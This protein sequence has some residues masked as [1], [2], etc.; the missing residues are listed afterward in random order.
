MSDIS[1]VAAILISLAGAVSSASPGGID[2]P[3]TQSALEVE[4]QRPPGLS[5]EV[6]DA[7]GFILGQI[8]S[9][10]AGGDISRLPDLLLAAIIAT[11]DRSFPNNPGIDIRG[12]LRA[13]RSYIGGGRVGGST[14][15]QQLAKNAI[16]GND[17]TL[18]R[19][20]VEAVLAARISASVDSSDILTGWMSQAWIGRGTYGVGGAARIWFDKDWSDVSLGEIAWI[21]GSLQGPGLYDPSRNKDRAL[22]R[23]NHVLGRMLEEGYITEE[24]YQYA[25][26]EDLVVSPETPSPSSLDTWIASAISHDIRNAS[27]L[28]RR[29]SDVDSQGSVKAHLTIDQDWQS[30]AQTILDRSLSPLRNDY[31]DIEG[32]VV[33]LDPQTGGLIASVGGAS[34]RS[35]YDRTRALRQPGSSVKPFIWAE[36]ISTGL[37]PD[38]LMLDQVK[39]YLSR[40][41]RWTP[42][43]YDR[44]ESGWIPLFVAL[45][46][47]SNLVAVSL[48]DMIG[49]ENA[50]YAMREAGLYTDENPGLEVLPSALGASEARLVDLAAAYSGFVNGGLSVTPHVLDMVTRE[51]EKDDI[52]WASPAP[53]Q[54]SPWIDDRPAAILRDMMYGV[55][56]RGTASRAFKSFAFPVIGKTGTSQDNRDA[57]FIGMTPDIVVAIWIGRDGGGRADGITGGMTAAPVFTDIMDLALAEGLIGIDGLRESDSLTIPWPPMLSSYGGSRLSTDRYG[58]PLRSEMMTS[59]EMEGRPGYFEQ[60]ENRNADL[61]GQDVRRSW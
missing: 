25:L 17:F 36:A 2:I 37:S 29:V 23:R 15:T 6:L 45:E 44:S 31:A 32:A 5:A 42:R 11:E 51:A 21:A 41:E 10:S 20:L 34:G 52:L 58:D 35:E 55:I 1:S 54:R 59:D 47:S 61:L 56:E 16:T 40:G 33:I 13:A 24:D 26:E 27:R 22:A 28:T 3:A 57:T 38:M 48:A 14:L 43:N 30:V 18:D 39:T 8:R 19:K 50:M 7:S 46:E 53:D 49:I 4:I 60:Q 9:S 12:L